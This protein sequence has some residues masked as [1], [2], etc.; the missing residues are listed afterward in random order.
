MATATIAEIERTLDRL[1]QSMVESDKR[2]AEA[3]RALAEYRADSD[4]RREETERVLAE[5]RA[6]TER[7]IRKM[8]E[9]VDRIAGNVGGLNRS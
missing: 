1:A 2:R 4:R 9:K 7:V 5:S 8:S 3:D 6:E